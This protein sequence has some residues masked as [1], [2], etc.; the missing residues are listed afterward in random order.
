[1]A[2]EYKIPKIIHYCWFGNGEMPEIL[3]KCM[4]S[5]REKCPEYEIKL[6]DEN[7]FNVNSL[8]YT[9]EAYKQKKYAFVSDVARL[10]AVYNDGGIYLDTDVMLKTSLD[11][12]LKYDAVFAA[13]DTMYI[14]TGLGF[15][16]MKNNKLVKAILDD[17]NTKEF[18][19][20]PCI[21]LNTKVIKSF[22][23]ELEF[24]QQSSLVDN[25]LFI[26]SMDVGKYLKHLYVASWCDDELQKKRL[27]KINKK[28]S[29]WTEFR[30][31]LICFFRQPKIIKYMTEHKNFFTKTYIFI[32]YD[33][34]VSGPLYFLKRA[35]NKIFRTHK[36]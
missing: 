11:E 29:K 22:Y 32:V 13:D 8:Q 16:A 2:D 31:K 18:S 10:W 27:E 36:D 20:E 12:W 26:G 30:W 5:W 6:W 3:Q 24:F 1:M 21:S 14:N 33:L 25:T 7:N 9:R 35:K 19:L 28:P 23:P 17:Y 15:A 4:E 34:Y